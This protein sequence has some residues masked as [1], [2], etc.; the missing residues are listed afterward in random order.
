LTSNYYR[1]QAQL[2]VPRCLINTKDES[3]SIEIKKTKKI[4][5]SSL[6]VRVYY[7][8]ASK[9]SAQ[10]LVSRLNSNWLKNN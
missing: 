7:P 4:A 8:K 2:K 9:K 5:Q 10:I 1:S 6:L 3:A